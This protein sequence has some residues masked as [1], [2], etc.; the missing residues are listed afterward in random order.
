MELRQVIQMSHEGAKKKGFWNKQRNIGEALMLV[1]SEL[2]EAIDAHQKGKFFDRSNTDLK[3]LLNNINE[4][5][6]KR[7]FKE[8]VK[9][10]F[11]DELA[12][13]VIRLFDLAGGM[14]VDLEKHILCKLRYNSTRPNLHGKNY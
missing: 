14:G 11:E 4:E 12:D 1:T 7:R 8:N 9:D 6:F 2:G 10:T 3:I 5:S 13:A